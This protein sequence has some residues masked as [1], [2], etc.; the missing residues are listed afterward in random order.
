MVFGIRLLL[1]LPAV[2]V[3]IIGVLPAVV[4]ALLIA[5]Q[6]RPAALVPGVFAMEL[7]LFAC[8]VPAICLA[9]LLSVPLSL[10][11][12]LAVRACVLEGRGARASISSAWSMLREHPGSLALVWL[13][14]LCVGI[15]VMVVVFLPLVL[16]MMA[17][18]AISLLVA[19]FSPLVSVGLMLAIG[20]SAWLLGAAVNSVVETFSSAVWTLTYRELTGLGLTGE[21]N[22]PPGSIPFGQTM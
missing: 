22:P 21:E 10:L 18:M 7:A 9:V 4:M 15:G 13:I 5:G 11:R 2:I 3:T 17:L 1:G 14:L 20:F 6:D 16:V 19:F 8:L 12:R